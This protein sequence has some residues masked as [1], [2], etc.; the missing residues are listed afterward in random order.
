MTLEPQLRIPGPTPLPQRVIVAAARQMINHRGPE[1]AELMNDITAGLQRVLHTNCDVLLFPASGTGGLEATVVNMLSPDEKALFCIIGSFGKRWADIADTYGVNVI[2]LEKSPGEAILAGD[3][4]DALDHDAGIS[5]VFV[6]HNETSTGV[7]NDM[8]SIAS[9]I[10]GRDKVL[11]IDSV[12]GAGC[13]PLLVDALG[14]DV[15]VCG[16][17]KGWMAPPGMSMIAVSPGALDASQRAALPRWYFDFAR[18]KA[19]QDK[20]QTLTTPPISVMYAMQEGLR[21]IGEEGVL[22]V[23]RRHKRIAGMIRAGVEAAASTSWPSPAFA[24][25]L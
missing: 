5:T 7:T 10:K 21:V 12:S 16:S 14:I 22:D 8:P 13:I 3:I 20:S 18:E 15:T 25:T 2:R 19:M 1:F 17:Q 23:W 11:C 9:A 24:V 6:T 4:E